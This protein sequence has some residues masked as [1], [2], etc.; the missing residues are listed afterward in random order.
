MI[1][2]VELI[3]SPSKASLQQ[4]AD[5]FVYLRR[6]KSPSIPPVTGYQAA[7]SHIYA[8]VSTN[9]AKNRVISLLFRSFNKPCLPH[10]IG[11]CDG[12]I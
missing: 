12:L 2:V 9:R 10:E 6:D 8:L 11:L 7:L 1:G 3:L 5:F 4:I